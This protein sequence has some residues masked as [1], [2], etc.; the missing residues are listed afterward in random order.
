MPQGFFSPFIFIDRKSIFP[1][2]LSFNNIQKTKQ[3]L[4]NMIKTPA[5][6]FQQKWKK[7]KGQNFPN[8]NFFSSW[9]Y[10]FFFCCCWSNRKTQLNLQSCGENMSQKLHSQNI[11]TTYIGCCFICFYLK[12]F[13]FFLLN[14]KYENSI[15]NQ[16]FWYKIFRPN[17]KL[18]FLYSEL[19]L[20]L[21]RVLHLYYRNYLQNVIKS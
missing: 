6:K 7:N 3:I 16:S 15:I 12:C 2:T 9:F 20:L 14:V 8:P 11:H 13:L 17:I 21:Y 18:S 4:I 19:C 5:T 1:Q 10:V